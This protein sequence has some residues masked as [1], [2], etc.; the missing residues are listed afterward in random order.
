M[1]RVTDIIGGHIGISADDGQRVYS[2]IEQFIRNRSPIVV[3]FESITTL[4]PSFLNTAIGQ[5]YGIYEESVIN[6]NLIIEGMSREDLAL[7]QHVREHA[8]R[9]YANREGYD[10]AWAMNDKRKSR[11]IGR[12]SADDER[13]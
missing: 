13:F 9:Y 12:C 1:V 8:K 5:L 2:K 6:D 10:L 4:V 3:S 7:L 11:A